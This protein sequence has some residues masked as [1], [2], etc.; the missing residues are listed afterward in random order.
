[1]NDHFSEQAEFYAKYRPAYPPELY[2]FIFSHLKHKRV[3]WDCGTGSGQVAS[4]LADHFDQV[5][6]SDISQKQMSYAPPKENIEYHNVSAE[7]TGFPSDLF[8]LI[9]VG[10]AIHWFDF[11]RFYGEVHRTT[12]PGALLA[13]F[14]YGFVRVDPQINPI[15][16]GFYNDMF[17]S[18]FYENRT[19]LDQRYRTIPFPFAEIPSPPFQIVLKWSLDDLEGYFNSWSSVQKFKTVKGFNPVDDIMR[20]VEPLWAPDEEKAVA[21]PVFLRLGR[22]QKG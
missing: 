14:G 17:S 2:N 1:M 11:D 21:F 3:A 8:D 22:I 18:Y 13:V 6:A 16:D 9:S 10:Q 5:Y 7:D 15:I 20:E 19:Y 12:A 4:Y